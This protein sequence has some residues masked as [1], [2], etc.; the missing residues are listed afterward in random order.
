[1]YRPRA[2]ICNLCPS[3]FSSSNETNGS[4]PFTSCDACQPGLFSASTG[5]I[6]CSNCP[7]GKSAHKEGMSEC[8]PCPEGT[9][10]GNENSRTC[11]ICT[12][13][14][15]AENIGN[16]ECTT[17]PAG[18]ANPNE[19]S[20][21][22]SLCVAGEAC[23]TGTGEPIICRAGFFTG[24]PGSQACVA[25]AIGQASFAPKSSRCV[26]CPSGTFS[27][28][29]NSSEC[30]KCKIGEFSPTTNAKECFLCAR[31]RATNVTASS[32]CQECAIR[33]RSSIRHDPGLGSGLCL[34][35]LLGEV[36][37]PDR[38]VFCLL[39][40]LCND[41]L[42]I[43]ITHEYLFFSFCFPPVI[44]QNFKQSY[45]T[46]VENAFTARKERTL[47]KRE[48]SC[49]LTHG[50]KMS[51]HMRYATIV[52]SVLHVAV[53]LFCVQ[54]MG[55]GEA[56]ISLFFLHRAFIRMHVKGQKEQ[57]LKMNT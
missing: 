10:S 16:D 32:I 36:Q 50:I 21:K 39:C 4:V 9:A 20:T 6:E 30:T 41:L 34:P 22:C 1:M 57:K 5:S 56:V 51:Q 15:Y 23:P 52:L 25:C 18:F 35:C 19:R 31:G 17:C 14:F 42:L 40:V 29:T 47:S 54:K 55:F 28:A 7:R 43:A 26:V 53:V 13:G 11:E 27:P 12:P 45:D 2:K 49:T 8:G 24:S 44:H 48:S 37:P 46:L 33:W 3:G 38:L